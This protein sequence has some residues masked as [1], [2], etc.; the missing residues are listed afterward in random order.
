[1]PASFFLICAVLSRAV[2]NQV[3]LFWEAAL[4]FINNFCL[5][6]L[7]VGQLWHVGPVSR[8][9]CFC[10]LLLGGHVRACRCMITCPPLLCANDPKRVYPLLSPRNKTH[11]FSPLY[12]NLMWKLFSTFGHWVDE[13]TVW[14]LYCTVTHHWPQAFASIQYFP[15][16]WDYLIPVW[17]CWCG[18]ASL[19][20]AQV[21]CLLPW[22]SFANP[23]CY[24]TCISLRWFSF[25]F[26]GGLSQILLHFFPD[27]ILAKC[28]YC[29]QSF[30]LVNF[31]STCTLS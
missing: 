30:T 8:E 5:L 15:L 17:S 23:C 21:I 10:L 18:P 25:Y 14:P 6:L 9:P 4:R 27:I 24:V 13:Q 16:T 19:F 7:S 28:S 26:A 29:K 2:C 31:S 1:M 3:S 22:C 11:C 12:C 20:T